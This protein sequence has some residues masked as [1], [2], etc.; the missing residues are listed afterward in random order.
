MG[1]GRFEPQVEFPNTTRPV[2]LRGRVVER[3]R[4]W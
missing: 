2:G 1:K 3:G 4:E